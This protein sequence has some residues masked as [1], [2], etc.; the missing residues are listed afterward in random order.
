MAVCQSRIAIRAG[1]TLCRIVSRVYNSEA[2]AMYW[3]KLFRTAHEQSGQL[4]MVQPVIVSTTRCRLSVA[5]YINY[6]KIQ[7]CST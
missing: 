3:P 2:S 7:N 6:R 4:I 1:D 5:E